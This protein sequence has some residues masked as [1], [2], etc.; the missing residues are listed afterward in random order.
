MNPQH[1]DYDLYCNPNRL[2]PRYPDRNADRLIAFTNGSPNF[3]KSFS[4]RCIQARPSMPPVNPQEAVSLPR[5]A[6][7]S[8][9]WLSPPSALPLRRESFRR[10][11][12]MK[13]QDDIAIARSAEVTGGAS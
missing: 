1:A 2:A 7:G 10:Q 9:R 11:A 3:S 6:F 13:E 4:G 12:T 5:D 8:S